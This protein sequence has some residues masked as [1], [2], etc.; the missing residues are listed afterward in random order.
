MNEYLETI[1]NIQSNYDSF[2]NSIINKVNKEFIPEVENNW[3]S[4]EAYSFFNGSFTNYINKIYS[5]F[6]VMIS[7]VNASINSIATENAVLSHSESKLVGVEQIYFPTSPI[8]T[9]NIKESIDNVKKIDVDKASPM[10]GII[11]KIY[12][13]GDSAI[14]GIKDAVSNASFINDLNLEYI[15]NQINFFRNKF[16]FTISNM[17]NET[18]AAMHETIS[19]TNKEP[20]NTIQ[21]DNETAQRAA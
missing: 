14:T 3:A 10:L 8:N 20:V 11:K 1:K 15:N 12:D 13:N 4:P 19:N 17:L 9:S 2:L 6:N 21:S 5:L 16:A 18:K 7:S